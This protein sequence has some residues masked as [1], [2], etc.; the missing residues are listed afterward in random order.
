MTTG[1]TQEDK[2]VADSN[3]DAMKQEKDLLSFVPKIKWI[4]P[5]L[6]S[7]LLAFIPF[8]GYSYLIGR[9]ETYGFSGV[10][11]DPKLYDLVLNALYGVVGP[12]SDISRISVFELFFWVAGLTLVVGLFVP[13]VFAIVSRCSK[14]VESVKKA[15]GT[16]VFKLNDD[17]VQAAGSSW[18]AF[19]RLCIFFWYK[20]GQI[21][22]GAL[23]LLLLTLA[24]ALMLMLLGLSGILLGSG[25]GKAVIKS[26]I[27]SERDFTEAEIKQGFAQHCAQIKINGE[28]VSG[29]RVFSDS[30]ST[31]FVTNEGSFQVSPEGAVIY[32]RPITRLDDSGNAKND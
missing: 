31:F 25:D 6:G 4:F 9:L 10:D 18:S 21:Y 28:L 13:I 15:E 19:F 8:F 7:A 5:I 1:Q 20:A 29:Q 11:I 27:C 16:N 14:Y 17:D 22:F 12:L 32:F 2:K 24:G 3:S 26:S 30:K 23:L